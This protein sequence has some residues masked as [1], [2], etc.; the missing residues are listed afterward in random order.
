MKKSCL[1]LLLFSVAPLCS[2]AD[3]SE[4]EFMVAEKC[5][6]C[7]ETEVYTRE[8]RKVQSLEQLGT[9]V[10]ACNTNTGAQWFDDEV[11]TVI[12]YLDKHFYKFGS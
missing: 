8:D 11:D 1:A 4:T 2:F 6:A 12:N 7:H 10:R 5:T 3:E 9:M